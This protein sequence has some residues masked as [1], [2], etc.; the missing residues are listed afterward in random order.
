MSEAAAV[1]EAAAR[2]RRQTLLGIVAIVIGTIVVGIVG[3][4]LPNYWLNLLILIA[5]WAYLGQCWNIMGGYAGQF[6]FGHAAFFGLGAYTSTVL[7]VDFGINPWIGMIVGAFLSLLLG[8]AI[9]KVSFRYRLKGPFFAL[10][11]L[12]VAESMRV[13][14]TNLEVVGGALG[15]IIP[16]N[17]GGLIEFQFTERLPYL[18]IILT[19]LA[20]LTA[21][22]LVGSRRRFGYYLRAIRE[23]EEA[24]GSLG[25]DYDR[26]KLL[27]VG[28]SAFV[29]ALGGTFYAQYLLFIEPGLVFGTG[30]SIEMVIRPLLGG[31]GTVLGPILG[32]AVL[33]PISEVTRTVLR[34]M[35]GADLVLFGLILIIVIVYL[36]QGIVGWWDMRR[37]RKRFRTADHETPATEAA[38]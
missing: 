18:Y 1:Q 15:I 7:S 31:L 23:D 34:G 33:T 27:A 13:L 12:A 9:G 10:T 6:S 14:F 4:F 37:L 16:L 11:T 3:T 21:A 25:V 38:A 30:I 26:Y 36:P 32:S 35:N 5:F 28:A 2:D 19:M 17:D 8:L 22:V 24:A 20:L 29:T